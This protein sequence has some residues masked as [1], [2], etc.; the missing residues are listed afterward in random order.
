MSFFYFFSFYAF[1]MKLQKVGYLD[2]DTFVSLCKK[3]NL[4]YAEP[5]QR[6]TLSEMLKFNVETFITSIPG[7]FNL[8][9]IDEKFGKNIAEAPIAF[10]ELSP[11]PSL[12]LFLFH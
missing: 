10:L 2:Y 12:S 5:M 11:S 1:D 7:K 4:F 9:P 6:G 8:P 3:F